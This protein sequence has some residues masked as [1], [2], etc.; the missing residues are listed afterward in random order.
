[1]GKHEPHIESISRHHQMKP[2]WTELKCTEKHNNK[3]QNKNTT[4]RKT[5][6]YRHINRRV[7]ESVCKRARRPNEYGGKGAQSALNI[8]TKKKNDANIIG[9]LRF[10]YYFV[11]FLIHVCLTACLT[12][13]ALLSLSHNIYTSG[14]DRVECFLDWAFCCCFGSVW[15]SFVLLFIGRYAFL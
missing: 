6:I 13:N 12:L 11:P 8:H 15:F 10:D 2:N 7:I 5:T 3:H 14:C 4:N 9:I 1:M